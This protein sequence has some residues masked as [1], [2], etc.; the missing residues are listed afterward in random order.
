MPT[1]PIVE[2]ARTWTTTPGW[3]TGL[4]VR[5]SEDGAT[6]LATAPETFGE[7]PNA[8][9]VPRSAS[10]GALL[11]RA[12]ATVANRMEAGFGYGALLRD[13]DDDGHTDLA[14]R[15]GVLTPLV[16]ST[17]DVLAFMRGPLRGDLSTDDLDAAWDDFQYFRCMDAAD[18]SGDGVRDLVACATDTPDWVGG[19]KVIE[20]PVAGSSSTYEMMAHG[21]VGYG[22]NGAVAQL[23]DDPELE[24]MVQALTAGQVWLTDATPEAAASGSLGTL[25]AEGGDY[26]Y[27]GTSLASGRVVQSD[28]PEVWVGAHGVDERSGRVQGFAIGD[29]LVGRELA[30]ITASGAHAFFGFT[31]CIADIDLDG[32]DDLVV[33]AP[34][35]PYFGEAQPGRV[36]LFAGPLPEGSH[37]ADELAARV[38]AVSDGHDGFGYALDCRDGLLVVGAPFEPEG[39]A[40]HLFEGLSW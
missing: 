33:G 9:I 35:D 32:H 12:S 10:S 19:I 11:D 38:L 5:F 26:D 22:S 21:D 40:V 2:S 13:M 18:V 20:G 23:D 8:Y 15:G 17:G 30:T 25:L 39:R 37:D 28:E 29:G 6:L 4:V 24:L 36:Y 3:L 34:G 14:I 16:R 7:G 27:L 1:V 31:E